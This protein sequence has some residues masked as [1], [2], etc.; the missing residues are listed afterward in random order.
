MSR[1]RFCYL[2]VHGRDA[3]AALE[4]NPVSS[5]GACSFFNGH[6]DVEQDAVKK[7]EEEEEE[8]SWGVLDLEP[9]SAWGDSILCL[10]ISLT[11]WYWRIYCIYV[12]EGRVGNYYLLVSSSYFDGVKVVKSYIPR[13][14]NFILFSHVTLPFSLDLSCMYGWII[15]YT[16]IVYGWIY[17]GYCSLLCNKGNSQPQRN[18]KRA[19]RLRG[20]RDIIMTKWWVDIQ[21]LI[22]I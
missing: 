22:H 21:T 5:S 11:R 17:D 4:L 1:T 14:R 3:N 9:H 16:G 10:L 7:K 15:V 6:G 19:P 13:W 18:K 2:H 20:F 12:I 8:E